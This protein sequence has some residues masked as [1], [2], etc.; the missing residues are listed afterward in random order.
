[1]RDEG[2][3]SLSQETR[4]KIYFDITKAALDELSAS[5]VL[6]RN[7]EDCGICTF[8]QY[9]KY[10]SAR[11]KEENPEIYKEKLPCFGSII[12]LVNS[13]CKMQISK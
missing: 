9:Q 11:K 13:K 4:Y 3:A 5:G 1:M 8:C 7:I 12:G 10:Y 2:I 6:K